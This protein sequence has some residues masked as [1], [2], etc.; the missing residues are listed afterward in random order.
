MRGKEMGYILYR[1][2]HG[3]YNEINTLKEDL[4]VSINRT[5]Y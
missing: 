4:A 5:F 3:R 1:R 2:E